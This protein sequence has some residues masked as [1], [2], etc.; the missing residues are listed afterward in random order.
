VGHG[1][2]ES[3][4]NVHYRFDNWATYLT[5]VQTLEVTYPPPPPAGSLTELYTYIG[6][7]VS[8]AVVAVVA[9][10]ILRRRRMK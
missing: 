4:A 3:W 9:I 8:A 5:P 1:V 10:V 2:E 7:G 6:A